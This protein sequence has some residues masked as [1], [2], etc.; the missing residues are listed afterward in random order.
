MKVYLK[1]SSIDNR[2]IIPETK[3]CWSFPCRVI[4]FKQGYMNRHRERLVASNWHMFGD[5]EYPSRVTWQFLVVTLISS[6]VLRSARVHPTTLSDDDKSHVYFRDDYSKERMMSSMRCMLEWLQ[7]WGWTQRLRRRGRK[8]QVKRQDEYSR[9]LNSVLTS[10]PRKDEREDDDRSPRFLFSL[11]SFV[12]CLECSEI[13]SCIYDTVKWV[14]RLRFQWKKQSNRCPDDTTSMTF[15]IIRPLICCLHH[16]EDVKWDETTR[17]TIQCIII[18]MCSSASC[19]FRCY[20]NRRPDKFCTA[21]SSC[22]YDRNRDSKVWEICCLR[23]RVCCTLPAD[24]RRDQLIS[25]IK[26]VTPKWGG[27]NWT[28]G[29][30]SRVRET[31]SWMTKGKPLFWQRQSF[32]VSEVNPFFRDFRRV[33][34]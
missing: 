24:V 20:R 5:T 14:F 7:N 30:V 33:W 17:K 31:S 3:R 1:S 4:E 11:S 18:C 8:R 12:L 6:T 32:P 22:F 13:L 29:S 25:S 16:K 23:S 34:R 19:L 26:R 2:W 21:S 15:E 28:R 10:N 9:R 27:H